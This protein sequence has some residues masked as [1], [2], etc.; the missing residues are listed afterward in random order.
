MKKKHIFTLLLGIF[1]IL[2]QFTACNNKTN[3]PEKKIYKASSP[4]RIINNKILLILGKDYYKRENI[5]DYLKKE[6][7]IGKEDSPVK[8]I[9]YDDMITTT[10]YPLLKIIPEKI[11]EFK[12]TILIS[13]GL[14]EGGGRYL[15]NE[16]RKNPDLV[17]ISLLPM[18]EILP[19]EAG[20]DLVVDFEI[21]TEI[22]SEEK[23]FKISDESLSLLLNSSVFMGEYIY[24]KKKELIKTPLEDFSEV[25]LNTQK[26][27]NI[28]VET[29]YGI[30]PYIDSD[31]G[32]P[33][34]KY[35]LV[36]KSKGSPNE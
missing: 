19:L 23:D 9:G 17:I 32:I 21:P 7:G 34:R 16:S 35:L 6:Y 27:F 29:D 13:L 33:S 14:P 31:T 25:F 5:L 1:L 2:P 15:I 24:A 12:P 22:L 10:K 18:D 11:K 20:S 28:T 26:F 30:K 8:I 36:Y 3:K 4:Q